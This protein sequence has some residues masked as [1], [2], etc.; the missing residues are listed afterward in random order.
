LEAY[1]VVSDEERDLY[2]KKINDVRDPAKKRELKI[3][4]FKKEKELKGR[5]EVRLLSMSV[6]C[7]PLRS[8]TRRR[9]GDDKPKSQLLNRPI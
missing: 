7:W 2:A 5:I 3:N 6:P 9:Y 1:K 8:L 4:Q